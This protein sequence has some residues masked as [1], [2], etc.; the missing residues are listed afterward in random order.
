MYT[1]KI[2]AGL[3]ADIA[4]IGGG[5]AGVFAAISA[6]RNNVDT[7]LV[8]K[9][10]RLGGT[11]TR[12]GVNYP[13]LF[14]AWGKQII[15][16]PCYE[17]IERT[18]SLGGAVMPEISFHPEN[19]WHEQIL[20]NPFVYSAVIY[21]MC[22]EAGVRIISNT[23]LADA[24]EDTD[25]VHL[26]LAGKDGM[27]AADVKV[28]IDATGDATLAR[29]LG[30]ECM[31]SE[32][33]Q[34]A[35]LCNHISGYD[36]SAV[37]CR[38]LKE[39]FSHAG[40]ADYVTP[41]LLISWLKN[42]KLDYHIPCINADTALGREVLEETALLLLLD[43]YRFLRT[44][45]G[46]ENFTVDYIA[47]ETGVRETNRILGEAV[48][49][50]EDYISGKSYDDAVSYAFYP[51]D[52]HVFS[53]IEQKFFEENIVGKIPYRALIP[54]GAK[55]LLCAG[56]CLSSDTYAN[57]GL[58]VEAVCMSSGQVAGCAAALAVHESD[59]VGN[60]DYDSLLASLREIGAI[61]PERMKN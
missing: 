20:L 18:I 60:I 5:T 29:F 58:R 8:E 4:V 27:C 55:R 28:A 56:R 9:N 33:Q 41:Q 32:Q 26:I 54:R 38:T 46:L 17:A 14:F 25:G 13:G 50:A 24:A 47:E 21:Q 6:A 30:Y 31:K 34:P 36:F 61:V 43:T 19:H 42:H 23:I 52:L 45:P 59:F 57:S 44:I 51:I 49:S 35:T 48:I 39:S 2:R 53:G 10:S 37:D 15:S 22:R 7:I 40:L 3:K 12:A 1:G 16:G 11:V